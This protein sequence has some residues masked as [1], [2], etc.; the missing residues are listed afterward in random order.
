MFIIQRKASSVNYLLLCQ[1]GP[2]HEEPCEEAG[3]KR[4]NFREPIGIVLKWSLKGK[5]HYLCSKL[6]VIKITGLRVLE[7]N[8]V[9]AIGNLDIQIVVYLSEIMYMYIHTWETA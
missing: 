7:F 5:F 2:C 9:F 4:G 1:P 6:I 3:K 8:P